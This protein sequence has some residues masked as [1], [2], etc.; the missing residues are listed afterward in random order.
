MDLGRL[1]V[2]IDAARA[3]RSVDAVFSAMSAQLADLGYPTHAY[4]LIA[5][6]AGPRFPLVFST[7]PKNW[8]AQYLERGYIRRDPVALAAP[9]L[10]SPAMWRDIFPIR[11][12]DELQRELI[13]ESRLAGLGEGAS[14]AIHGPERACATLNVAIDDPLRWRQ[15]QHTVHLVATYAHEQVMRIAFDPGMPRGGLTPR[16]IECL[17]WTAHGKTAWEISEVLGCGHETVR[18][19]L[20]SACAKL[21]VY[22]KAAAAARAVSL[23]LVQF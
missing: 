11:A 3:A 1:E 4:Q 15:A 8:A 9:R 5:P 13:E 7:Y 2:F 10:L 14:V 19:H 20:K 18:Q 17:T 21:G 23:G 12:E 16:E 6:P 22:Q